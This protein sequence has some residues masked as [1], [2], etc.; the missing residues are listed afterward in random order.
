[1]LIWTIAAGRLHIRSIV[2][3]YSTAILFN[4]VAYFAGF[5]PV[6]GYYGYLTGWLGDKNFSGLVYCL[7]GLLILSFARNKIEV[8][9]A[10]VVFSRSAVGYGFSYLYCGV[11]C[12]PDLDCHREPSEDFRSHCLGCGPVLAD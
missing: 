6:T 3:G 7:F 4:A 8:I 12:R 2:L 5:A 9:V 11:C 1:M 10:I